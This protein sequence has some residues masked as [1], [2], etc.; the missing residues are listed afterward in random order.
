MIN[1]TAQRDEPNV[2]IDGRRE[3]PYINLA[4]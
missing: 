2:Y 3:G 1:K 4:Y